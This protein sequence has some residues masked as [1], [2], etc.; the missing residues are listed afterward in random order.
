MIQFKYLNKMVDG[1]NS[2]YHVCV[3][4][5]KLV[6]KNGTDSLLE[7]VGEQLANFVKDKHSLLLLSTSSSSSSWLM[8]VL[9]SCCAGGDRGTTVSSQHRT[10][11]VVKLGSQ[12]PNSKNIDVI[13][14]WRLDYSK[15]NKI[16][17]VDTDRSVSCRC[18][19]CLLIPVFTSDLSENRR[20]IYQSLN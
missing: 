16:M 9:V 2:I 4:E 10:V 19:W 18:G 7:V 14:I 5:T 20:K 3:Q 13:Q 17:I 11:A 6:E 1:P 12:R 8:M 15:Q